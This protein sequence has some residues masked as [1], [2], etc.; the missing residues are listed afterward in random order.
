MER[1]SRFFA[2][3]ERAM[4]ALWRALCSPY[5]DGVLGGLWVGV[6]ILWGVL[7]YGREPLAGADLHGLAQAVWAT[8]GGRAVAVL[9][10]GVACLR[11]VSILA[12]WWAPPPRRATRTP[13]HTVPLAHPPTEE[14]WR[15]VG[16]ALAKALPVPEGLLLIAQSRTR[17]RCARALLPLGVLVFI[18]ALGVQ[19]ALGAH[20]AAQPLL[21]GHRAPLPFQ[22]GCEVG[23]DEIRAMPK[24]KGLAWVE[25]DI[26]CW[27]GSEALGSLMI[28]KGRPRALGRLAFYLSG[29][30]PAVRLSAYRQ[31]AGDREEVL[32]LLPLANGQGAQPL[33]R[34]GFAG[35]EE[36][37]VALP[38]QNLIVRLVYYPPEPHASGQGA[39]VH[40]QALSGRDG[41][42]LA[43]EFVRQGAVQFS[44][45]PVRLVA[46]PEYYILLGAERRAAQPLFII[47]VLAGLAGLVARFLWPPRLVWLALRQEG[48]GWLGDLRASDP[49][50]EQ[51]ALQALAGEEECGPN[52]GS[53]AQ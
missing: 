12:P 37:Q 27:K 48:E 17:L 40:V 51:R 14:A 8:R 39:V 7:S 19:A 29:Y 46:A 31:G 32:P 5:A 23:L 20:S 2:P 36:Q 1:K 53:E 52:G 47:G 33:V 24:G 15:K 3:A 18:G 41:Q 25:A 21:L 22:G 50:L 26:T 34:V 9:L 6:A 10:G 4:T 49:G 35:E 43:E 16:L 45:G 28:R 11:L 44:V 38:A 30:G 42:V 13:H